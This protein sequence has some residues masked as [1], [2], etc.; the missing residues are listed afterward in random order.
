MRLAMKLA[1]FATTESQD[2][3]ALER[4]RNPIRDWRERMLVEFRLLRKQALRLT[5][6]AITAALKAPQQASSAQEVMLPTAHQ[7][8]HSRVVMNGISKSCHQE[9]PTTIHMVPG[10]SL[11]HKDCGVL[12]TSPCIPGL[13]ST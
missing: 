9:R 13:G 4:N 6:E 8:C 2:R 5:T 1:S 11:V 12:L 7:R 3:A 10:C